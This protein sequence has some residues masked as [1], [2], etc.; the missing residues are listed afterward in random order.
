LAEA[1][2]QRSQSRTASF[3]AML[4]AYDENPCREEHIES[5][6]DISTKKRQPFA[7]NSAM[8]RIAWLL[9]GR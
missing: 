2:D 4:S 1:A 3:L 6:L 7:K 8:N 5:H 9:P